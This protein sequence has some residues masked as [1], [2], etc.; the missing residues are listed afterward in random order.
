MN[1][2]EILEFKLRPALA[3]CEQ[4]RLRMHAAWED[5]MTFT[6]L[7]EGLVGE[8]SEEQIRTLDQLLFRFGKLQDAIGTRLL[9]AILQW[10]QEWQDNAPFLDKL[11]RAEKL[12]IMPSVEQWQFLRELRNQTAHEYPDQPELVKANLAHLLAQVPALEDILRRMAGWV[13]KHE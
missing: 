3:E 13:A 4:H 6:P 2:R 1:P 5:A 7:Q 9:P 8:L 10:V 11:N 12:G